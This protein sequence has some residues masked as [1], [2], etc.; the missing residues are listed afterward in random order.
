MIAIDNDEG[1]LLD[2]C[3]VGT[4]NAAGVFPGSTLI[5]RANARDYANDTYLDEGNATVYALYE[6]D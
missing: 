4:G 6:L 1:T 5:L 3:E 2:V